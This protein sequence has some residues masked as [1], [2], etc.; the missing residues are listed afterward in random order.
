MHVNEKV[1][2]YLFTDDNNFIIQTIG[3]T[4][5]FLG[6]INTL[7]FQ[8]ENQCLKVHTINSHRKKLG[9]LSQLK[10]QE[11]LANKLPRNLLMQP[12]S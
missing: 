5:N 6:L 2:I 8:N 11:K 12:K 7:K 1:K 4:E 10:Q 9:K 3:T